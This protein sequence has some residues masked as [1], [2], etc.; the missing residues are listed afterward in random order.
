MEGVA[1]ALE[2][3]VIQPAHPKTVVPPMLFFVDN[4]L[5]VP[6]VIEF[7]KSQLPEV[8]WNPEYVHL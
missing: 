8:P 3:T 2:V 1:V 5:L 6:E 7:V 4:A